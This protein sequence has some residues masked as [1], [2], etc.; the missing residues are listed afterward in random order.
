MQFTLT[1]LLALAAGALAIPAGETTAA[2]HTGDLTFFNPGLGACGGTNGDNDLIT[3][4]SAKLFDD[5]PLCGRT[6]RVS[7]NGRSADVKI[8]D[9]CEGCKEFDLDLSPAAFKDVVGD[10]GVGRTTGSWK[11]L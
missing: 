2:T 11:L 9:R 5:Q 3:A 6:I 8:V 4:I 1:T 10:L 7:K